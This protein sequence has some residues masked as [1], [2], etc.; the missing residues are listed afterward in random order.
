MKRYLAGIIATGSVLALISSPSSTRA[1]QVAESP[2]NRTIVAEFPQKGSA[3]I[4]MPGE[5]QSVRSWSEY[6]QKAATLPL[7]DGDE[8]DLTIRVSIPVQPQRTARPSPNAGVSNYVLHFKTNTEHV[9]RCINRSGRHLELKIE[10]Y[11]Q[12]VSFLHMC[13]WKERS[14]PQLGVLNSTN[15]WCWR[16]NVNWPRVWQSIF[17]AVVS[18]GVAKLF[19]AMIA[20]LA[21]PV[22][23]PV[24]L[25]LAV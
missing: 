23:Y 20:N 18:V 4:V 11:G 22:A 7:F 16:S 10:R 3:R 24:L 2:A 17:D 8:Q 25:M 15:G 1:T 21:T 6:A 13:A 9:G 19:A 5:S 14:G 12:E